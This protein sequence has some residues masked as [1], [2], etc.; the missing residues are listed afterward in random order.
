MQPRSGAAVRARGRTVVDV[1]ATTYHVWREDRCIRLGAGLAYYSLFA[2]VPTLTLTASL[3]GL[4]FSTEDVSAFLAQ[5]L[6]ELLG[7]DVDEVATRL[8]DVVT[9]SSTTTSLGLIGLA[10]LLIAGS[11]VFVALQDALDQIWDVPPEMGIRKGAR[12]RLLAFV[13]LLATGGMLVAAFAVQTL[14]DAIEDLLPS[15]VWLLRAAGYLATSLVPLA[16]FAAGL[17]ALFFL[18]PRAEVDRRAA[19]IGGAVTSVLA[20]LGA[21]AV[22]WYFQRFGT[23]SVSAAAGTILIILT[24]F[25]AEAQIVLV[26]AELTK[27]L[28]HRSGPGGR[29][30]PEAAHEDDVGG[31]AGR[32]R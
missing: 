16:V 21:V 11:L 12:R 3:A 1:L 28:T 18:L 19:I 14:L 27:V 29:R 30:T 10:T 2:L 25:Y 5:P 20:A 24:A 22:G 23:T 26:G 13:T 32:D 31:T 9:A 4:L 7:Q 6:S 8:A 17:A 15:S